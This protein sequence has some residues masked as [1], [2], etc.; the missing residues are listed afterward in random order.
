MGALNRGIDRSDRPP[1][2]SPRVRDDMLAPPRRY[3]RVDRRGRHGAEVEVAVGAADPADG[4]AD[5][6]ALEVAGDEGGE[7]ALEFPGVRVAQA[8]TEAGGSV[9]AFIE[10]PDGYRIELVQRP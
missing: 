3:R 7:A 10:D 4:L 1:V 8:E 5:P 6:E 9:I 2:C